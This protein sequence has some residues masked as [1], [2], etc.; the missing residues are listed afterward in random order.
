MKMTGLSRTKTAIAGIAV[1]LVLA[2]LAAYSSYPGPSKSVTSTSS[3]PSRSSTST[4][5]QVSSE[6][7][8]SSL[9]PAVNS[10][11]ASQIGEELSGW[12]SGLDDGCCYAMGYYSNTSEVEWYGRVAP[13]VPGFGGGNWSGADGV[14][15]L[16]DQA[17]GTLRASTS[18]VSVSNVTM[19]YVQG[20]VLVAFH[21]ALDG[22][23]TAY[24]AVD[25]KVDVRQL[26]APVGK[27]STG[28]YLQ[29][30]S[31]DF[32][33]SYVQY[34]TPASQVSLRISQWARSIDNVCCNTSSYYASSPEI[35]W[36]GDLNAPGSPL[37]NQTWDGPNT[38]LGETL[39]FLLPSPSMVTVSEL[40]VETVSNGVVNATFH[41]V[42][43]GTSPICGGPVNGTANVQMVWTLEGGT[44]WWQIE[45]ESW[46]FTSSSNLP[47]VQDHCFINS[48]LPSHSGMPPETSSR[49]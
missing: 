40:R 44:A 10:T 26:W 49:A 36:Y 14:K 19:G 45:H 4:S 43:N 1:I 35:N 27:E 37:F 33:S 34:S 18:L 47:T 11:D 29:R 20:G 31:W 5:S 28:W 8:S 22:S 7:A 24:G 25:A 46:D 39:A 17:L 13:G 21:L 15:S 6:T 23:S 2:G 12:V 30:D 41:L 32:A 9:L 38:Y 48:M 16:F 3:P 42:L